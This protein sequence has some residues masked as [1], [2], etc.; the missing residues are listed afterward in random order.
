MWNDGNGSILDAALMALAFIAVL[1]L[2]V[3]GARLIDWLQ[4]ADR[5]TRYDETIHDQDRD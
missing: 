4:T 5:S 2:S 1:A 3:G